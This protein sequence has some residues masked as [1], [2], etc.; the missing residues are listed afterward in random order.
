MRERYPLTKSG[1]NSQP[2]GQWQSTLPQSHPPSPPPIKDCGDAVKKKVKTVALGPRL[3]R[4]VGWN[5]SVQKSHIQAGSTYIIT[6][7]S[8]HQNSRLAVQ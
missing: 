5:A 7:H 3:Y 6:V 8:Q 2:L 4:Q 1:S